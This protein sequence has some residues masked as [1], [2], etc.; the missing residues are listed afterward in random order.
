MKLSGRAEA[1][2]GAEGA[3]SLSA[4]GAKPQADHAPLQRLLD[5]EPHHGE[6]SLH[7]T[8]LNSRSGFSGS[9]RDAIS[10]PREETLPHSKEMPG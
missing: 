2:D 6:R 7:G 10:I 1:P 9:F 4:R 3:H 5:G 8:I